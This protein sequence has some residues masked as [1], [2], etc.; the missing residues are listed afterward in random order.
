M[1]VP[2]NAKQNRLRVLKVARKNYF[3]RLGHLH[4]SNFQFITSTNFLGNPQ[5]NTTLRILL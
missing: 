2:C 1:L 4:T 3:V 5:A